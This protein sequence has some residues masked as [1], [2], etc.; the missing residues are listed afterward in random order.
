MISQEHFL[1]FYYYY[2]MCR[3]SQTL[4]SAVVSIHSARGGK[5]EPNGR[6]RES[7]RTQQHE[8]GVSSGYNCLPR[9]PSGYTWSIRSQFSN[10]ATGVDSRC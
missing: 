6:S 2:N 4:Y 7:L 8:V 1:H 10:A 5:E 3:Y 9:S